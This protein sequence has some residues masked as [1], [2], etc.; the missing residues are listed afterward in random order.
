M[1][2]R[3][4][5]K[6]GDGGGAAGGGKRRLAGEIDE[7]L[8]ALGRAKLDQGRDG[9]RVGI[10]LVDGRFDTDCDRCRT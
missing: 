7:R 10:R 4:C 6:G 1:S 9:G 2:L 5:A 8:L 3:R